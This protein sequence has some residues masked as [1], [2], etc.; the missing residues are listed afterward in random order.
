MQKWWADI[1]IVT[2][3]GHFDYQLHIVPACVNFVKDRAERYP[4]NESRALVAGWGLNEHFNSSK[5]LQSF[6]IPVVDFDW[7]EENAP[8]DFKDKVV[9]DKVWKFLCFLSLLTLLLFT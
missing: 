7:C 4:K 2:I 9:E 1:A 3:E 6:D 5:V 8:Q